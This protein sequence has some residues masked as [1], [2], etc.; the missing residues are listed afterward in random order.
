MNEDIIETLLSGRLA[1]P[2][3]GPPLCVP[4]RAVAIADSLAGREAELVAGLDF[5][6][7]RAGQRR[8]HP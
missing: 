5:G 6:P 1:D 8:R 2:D 3:G 4:T 7:R